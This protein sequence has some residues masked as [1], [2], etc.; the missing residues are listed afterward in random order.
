MAK[1]EVGCHCIGGLSREH[2][3]CTAWLKTLARVYLWVESMQLLQGQSK[4]EWVSMQQQTEEVV[5]GKPAT[6]GQLPENYERSTR[7]WSCLRVEMTSGEVLTPV[8]FGAWV[9]V[10]ITVE[11]RQRKKNPDSFRGPGEEKKN[12]AGG[13]LTLAGAAPVCSTSVCRG[14]KSA[15][16][17]IPAPHRVPGETKI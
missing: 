5:E 4:P 8:A 16:S 17:W 7:G 1:C 10:E 13:A 2:R 15:I 11:R 3:L 6:R 14:C 9:P 12:L